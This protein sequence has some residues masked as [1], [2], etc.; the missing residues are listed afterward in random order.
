MVKVGVLSVSFFTGNMD[1][2]CDGNRFVWYS[3]P[4]EALLY[5]HLQIL[6]SL[7]VSCYQNSVVGNKR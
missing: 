4:G 7:T 2:M 5:L 3:K 6:I 1:E